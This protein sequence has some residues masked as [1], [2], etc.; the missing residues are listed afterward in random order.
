MNRNCQR[1]I[2]SLAILML[3]KDGAIESIDVNAREYEEGN[4]PPDMGAEGGSCRRKSVQ[5]NLMSRI[6]LAD[7]IVQ[8]GGKCFL[9]A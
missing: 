6:C 2:L 3:K 8:Y 9:Q 7:R 1:Q 5:C 4:Q